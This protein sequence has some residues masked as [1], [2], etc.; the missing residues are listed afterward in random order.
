MGQ[1]LLGYLEVP[2]A[3]DQQLSFVVNPPSQARH[4]ER[5][6]NAGD[7]RTKLVGCPWECASS[8]NPMHHTSAAWEAE[9]EEQRRVV[10]QGAMGT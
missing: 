5:V 8:S 3:L 9:T 1:V 2:A 6:W 7:Q 4:E 10:Q